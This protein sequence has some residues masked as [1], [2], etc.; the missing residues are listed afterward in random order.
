MTLSRAILRRISF[1]LVESDSDRVA[2]Q[3]CARRRKRGASACVSRVD[4]TGICD[5]TGRSLFRNPG[6]QGVDDAQGSSCVRGCR[7]ACGQHW[8]RGVRAARAPIGGAI[9][10]KAATF[11][12]ARGEQPDDT[13]RTDDRWLWRWPARVFHCA[14]RRSGH[15][16]LEGAGGC[17]GRRAARLRP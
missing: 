11:T 13:A 3:V 5:L 8:P 1:D 4:I 15:G 9:H 2:S 17:G 16:R 6:A 12:P 10:L 14:V 7:S